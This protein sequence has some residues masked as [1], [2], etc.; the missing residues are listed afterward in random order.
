MVQKES[1]T[2]LSPNQNIMKTYK[3]KSLLYFTGFLLAS[4]F[5]Y[6]VEQYREFETEFQNEPVLEIA[7]EDFDDVEKK[8]DRTQP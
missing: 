3:F 1:V 7:A 2:S 5:Y 8:E 6:A 4:T